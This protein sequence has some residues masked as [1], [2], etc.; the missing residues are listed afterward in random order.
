MQINFI[1]DWEQI[2]QRVKIVWRRL[3]DDDLKTIRFDSAIQQIISK[4]QEK[5][6]YSKE[7]AIEAFYLAD[8]VHYNV[9][10]TFRTEYDIV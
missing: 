9:S 7:Q 6:G 1:E 5:Y 8:I 3:T 10:G 4:L 2:K